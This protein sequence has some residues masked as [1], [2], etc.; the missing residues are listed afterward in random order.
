MFLHS[1][2]IISW[3]NRN[4][5]LKEMNNLDKNIPDKLKP[6]ESLNAHLNTTFI[7]KMPGYQIFYFKLITNK[8]PNGIVV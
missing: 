8:Q 3:E 2:D 7:Q 6:Q 4:L 5:F 1:F